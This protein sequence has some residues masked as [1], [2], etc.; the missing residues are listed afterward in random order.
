[1]VVSRSLHLC[2]IN[3]S[4]FP[5]SI[6]KSISKRSWIYRF[7]YHRSLIK[8]SK[9]SVCELVNAFI[10]QI[11]KSLIPIIFLCIVS[12][13]TLVVITPI[14]FLCGKRPAF[15]NL[16]KGW[17]DTPEP[18]WFKDMPLPSVGSFRIVPIV[19]LFMICL[20]WLVFNFRLDAVFTDFGAQWFIRIISC[21]G[22]LGCL[23]LILT[24]LHQFESWRVFLFYL[25]SRWNDKVCFTLD[26]T[27]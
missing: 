20:V 25:K 3:L 10:K 12:V 8:P 1:M 23:A 7:A 27:D 18:N 21:I 5:Y 16:L 14:Q 2:N 17:N 19:P 15:I 11:F 9:V 4:R 24:A 22:V 26:V 6:M 13:V